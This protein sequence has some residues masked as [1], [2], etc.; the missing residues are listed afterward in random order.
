MALSTRVLGAG[1]LLL[2]AAALVATYVTAAAVAAKV[3]LRSREVTVPSLVGQ[4]LSVATAVIGNAGL[5]LRV[6][7]TRRADSHVA[8]GGIARQDPPAGSVAR[9]GRTVRVWLSAGGAAVAVPDLTGVDERSA[10]LQVQQGGL[11]LAGVSEIR[12]REA[13]ADVVV[14][15]DPPAGSR[16]G[17]VSLL[18]NR[19]DRAAAYVMPDLIGLEAARVADLLRA[20]GFRVAVVAQSPYP[21]VPPGMVIRQSPQA[22]F[23]LAPGDAVSLEVSR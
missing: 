17:A 22:G 16:A 1:R 12:S 3:A 8:P 11:L 13:P 18:V 15:Q 6:D 14:A 20:D 5:T 21:G 2:I 23:Q 4:P 9:R 19:G 10:R 7:E